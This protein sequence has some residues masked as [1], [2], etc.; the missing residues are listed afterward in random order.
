MTLAIHSSQVVMNRRSTGGLWS[1][2]GLLAAL[3]GGCSTATVDEVTVRERE[4]A[5][6]A[7]VVD[8]APPA[9]PGSSEAAPETTAPPV[10]ASGIPLYPSASIL[11]PATIDTLGRRV[12]LCQALGPAAPHPVNGI[13]CVGGNCNCRHGEALWNARKPI[14]W[15]EYGQGEYIGPARPQH[16]PEYRVRVDDTLEFIYR[17]TR[18]ESSKPYELNVG[19]V[20][21]VESLTDAAIDRELTIQPDGTITLRLLGQVRAGRRTVDELRLDL[22]ERYKKYY[23]VPAVT[24]TPLKMNTRLED[25]RAAVN[26]Q[27]G[28][29]GQFRT[30][31]VTPDGM[32]SLVAVGSVPAQGLTLEEL[33]SEVNERYAQVVDG[34]EVTP[35]LQTRA[36][37][38]V[39]VIG[40]VRNPGR[41]TLDGPT[42]A[43]QSLALAGG[44][45]NGGNIREIVVFR[46]ADDWRLMATRL[47]LRGALLG[48][49]PCPADEIWL[50]DSDLVVVPKTP[51]L[52]AADF[53][54]LVFTRGIYGVVPFQGVSVQL[55]SGT[56]IVGP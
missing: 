25:I 37:R 51:V 41:F 32:V 46:R 54:D 20:I 30:V 23:K 1:A 26:S 7:V 40:E 19:D 28:A 10:V 55:G 3:V 34:L 35:V 53:I 27:Y 47:D 2:A 16:T 15:Q 14:A 18:N 5:P 4:L 52:L 45:V 39:Y 44:W 31:R 50:R 8:E 33:A 29:G 48:K 21:K 42:T 13:D 6:A 43:M 38:F 36:P 24:I 9:A 17:L 22:E 56:G 49:R 11:S 12:V